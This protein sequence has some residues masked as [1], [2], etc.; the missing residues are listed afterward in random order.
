MSDQTPPENGYDPFFVR[1]QIDEI[2][3]QEITSFI[4]M[5][6]DAALG[7]YNLATLTCIIIAVERERE[8]KNFPDFP[9]ERYTRESFMEE[10][11]EIGFSGTDELEHTVTSVADMGYIHFSGEG[12]LK[13]G[14]SAYTMAG[15]LDTMFPGMPGMNLIAFVM[16]MNDEVTSGR[17]SLELAKTSFAQT[18]KS[19]GVSVTQEKAEA[20]A[21][22][23]ATPKPIPAVAPQS[24]ASRAVSRKLK[25]NAAKQIATLR[26]KSGAKPG[27]Y[28]SDGSISKRSTVKDIFSAG[29][30]EE[31]LEAERA[32][33]EAAEQEKHD[34]EVRDQELT[35]REA[36]VLEAEER[37][38]ELEVREQK[39][40]EAQEAAE[41]AEQ[42]ARK[43]VEQESASIAAREAELEAMEAKLAAEK[44]RILLEKEAAAQAALEKA[45]QEAEV[46]EAEE[47]IES[48]IAAFEAKLAMPCPLCNQGKIVSETTPKDKTYYSCS[49]TECRFVSWDKPYHF[50]CPLCKNPFLTEMET[51][52][53]EKG[54]KCPRAACSYTQKNLLEPAQNLAAE[55]KG[56][57]RKKKIVRRVK[58][59]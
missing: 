16:Q 3:A 33:L 59:R 8:I 19:R 53:G 5:D 14:A 51:P 29:P 35:E 50:E 4:D 47:D 32:A 57:K 43:L 31:E 46:P 27:L 58:R 13:I 49:N 15:F 12:E 54:L 18:L 56:P 2:L 42:K 7:A 34:A 44:A 40:K 48:Q 25:E 45:A 24:M 28:S 20:K 37:A 23:L 30:S 36:R 10:L 9:P 21:S 39:L 55:A 6:S 38:K 41:A 17:K 1:K 11:A 52:T 22:E 26:K